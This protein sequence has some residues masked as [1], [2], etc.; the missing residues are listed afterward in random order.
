[1]PR[2]KHR[3]RIALALTVAAACG[4]PEE[5]ASGE[6]ETAS[7]ASHG[8]QDHTRPTLP[9]PEV[10][11]TLPPD[12][13]PDWNRL[14]FEQSPYLLQ[15][16][17]N[18]VDWWPWG[19]AAFAEA[20]RRD[21][22]VFLSIG[23]STCHW[24]HVME[25]ESFEDDEVAELLNSYFVCVKVDREERPDVDQLYMSVLQ[26]MGKRGGWPMTVVMTPDRLPFFGGTYFPRGGRLG[27]PGLMELL[28][29]LVLD[30]RE[31]REEIEA[32]GGNVTRYLEEVSAGAAGE[33]PGV[34]V[35]DAAVAYFDRSFDEVNGGFG[36][37]PK[38]PAPHNSRLLL[39]HHR[40]TGDERALEMAERT[41]QR[42]RLG[43][44]FDQVG[45][46]FH[47]YSTDARWFLPH[48][49]KMLYDQALLAMAYLE[50]YQVTGDE[51]YADVARE[52][53]TY[54]LRD[55]TSPEGGFYSAEDADS[56]G[57]EGLFYTWTPA[58]VV[59]VLGAEDGELF[60][61][62]YGISE[63]GNFVEQGSGARTGRSIPFLEAPLAELAI[64]LS[65]DASEL[66]ERL[67]AGRAR[68]FEVREERIHP[69]KDDKILA[70]WNGLM[71]AALATGA[72]VLG[73]PAYDHAAVR[74]AEFLTT[75]L[76]NEDGRLLKR[77]RNGEANLPAVLDDYAF[78]LW[79]L[80]ELHQATHE[81]RWLEWATRYADLMLAHFG[82][83]EGGALFLTADDGEDLIVR[84]R[85]FYDGALP[86]GNSAAA[87]SLVRLGRLLARTDYE[88]AADAIVRGFAGNLEAGPAGY[89]VA[90]AAVEYALGPAY[91]VVVV[92]TPD[93]PDTEA[94][95]DVLRRE[96]LPHAVV[97]FR[98]DGEAGAE[99]ARL[100]PFT[101]AMVALEGKATA[102]V[103]RNHTCDAPTADL[104]A[105]LAALRAPVED[106]DD[107]PGQPPADGETGGGGG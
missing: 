65:L 10:I 24:C 9:T 90:L 79:G 32:Y 6:K 104:G 22:P 72:R 82:D 102:Y 46:G 64:E 30:W 84:T 99:V 5:I 13:G 4:G 19:D 54:V 96:Y 44:M 101:E 80:I 8:T 40:R 50:A 2:M 94:M 21:V 43:G 55:M 51:H 75:E 98:P 106:V 81:P 68:L 70:D 47:R 69:L 77:W 36:S 15:H 52:I 100:A 76:T 28:G 3:R 17:G 103:C 93:E 18:P 92:G 49:E 35:L 14:V 58:E 71:I 61:R 25:H 39:R 12:G 85:S 41:L 88:E 42:M 83:P 53:F 59:E 74:A 33:F 107:V 23:Y 63:G 29:Q 95:L 89:T 66:E 45:L 57:E 60:N 67:E 87:W 27:Q 73:E 56:E 37:E 16:A 38:F 34:S 105:V 1:M 86:S 11:A 20:K 91:E 26:G 78:A 31:S 62:V 48:F 97:L 7:T